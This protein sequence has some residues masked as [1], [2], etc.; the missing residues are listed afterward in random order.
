VLQRLYLVLKISI[1]V[2]VRCSVNLSKK[3]HRNDGLFLK[4]GSRLTDYKYELS[5]S[6]MYWSSEGY[7]YVCLTG[8]YILG[9][10]SLIIAFQHSVWIEL[11]GWWSWA[12]PQF[13]AAVSDSINL[14]LIVG[15]LLAISKVTLRHRFSIGFIS[16]DWAGK[17]SV[18]VLFW[19]FQLMT[20][21]ARWHGSLSSF[22][23]NGYW[24]RAMLLA[25]R[26]SAVYRCVWSLW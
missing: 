13:Q 25:L 7:F 15:C 18:L 5:P 21:L 12:T 6:C 26:T 8:Q 3:P 14:R 24:N 22:K 4:V 1:F 23:Q 9:Q 16:C 19:H 17:V 11:T 20:S 10:P 2:L